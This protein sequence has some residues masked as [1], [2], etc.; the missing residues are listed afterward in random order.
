MDTA[1][2][3]QTTR[4]PGEEPAAH[5][6]ALQRTACLSKSVQKALIIA[7][8]EISAPPQQTAH[9]EG[10]T[11]KLSCRSLWG[12]R[13][14][15]PSRVG[16]ALDGTGSDSQR[17]GCQ[18]LCAAVPNTGDDAASIPRSA[19]HRQREA[20][21]RET[22]LGG[23]HDDLRDEVEEDVVAVGADGGVAGSHLQLIHR[24]QE[25]P[26]ALVLQVLEGSLLQRTERLRGSRSNPCTRNAPAS[27]RTP[28]GPGGT[29]PW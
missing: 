13:I 29:L 4:C 26:F 9:S 3:V 6:R 21:H 16:W 8:C 20:G 17:G 2:L 11:Q 23:I 24:L 25:Q 14:H 5:P 15:P 18:P 1:P 19:P 12:C 10:L 28:R 7:K 27:A 22:H